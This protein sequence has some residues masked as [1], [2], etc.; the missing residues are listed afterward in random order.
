MTH[1]IQSRNQGKKGDF[2]QSLFWRSSKIDFNICILILSDK[3]LPPAE[4]LR[5][6]LKWTQWFSQQY[7][8]ISFDGISSLEVFPIQLCIHYLNDNIG[9]NLQ[10]RVYKRV[11]GDCKTQFTRVRS[12][13][14][15]VS[16]RRGRPFCLVCAIET[17][18]K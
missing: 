13:S 4:I 18:P 9:R 16:M 1:P 15:R 12:R 2:F 11:A 6:N 3:F 5:S 10:S 7:A 8:I 17:V 14:E